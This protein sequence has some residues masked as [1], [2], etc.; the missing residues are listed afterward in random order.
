MITRA[1]DAQVLQSAINEPSHTSS[2][3]SGG[4]IT[5]YQHTSIE[6]V[7]LG[8]LLTVFLPFEIAVQLLMQLCGIR[9]SDDSVW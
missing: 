5:A 1:T 2:G 7:R 3:A 8:C 9:I 6:L 4:W